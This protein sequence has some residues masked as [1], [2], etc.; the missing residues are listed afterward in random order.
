MA[1][2]SRKLAEFARS[3]NLPFLAVH[4][5]NERRMLAEGSVSRFQLRR[6]FLTIAVEKDFGFDLALWRELSPV[7]RA[8]RAFQPDVVHLT[9]PG[10]TGLLGLYLAHS[11]KI[12]VVAS[13]HTNLHEFAARRL[14]KIAKWA[15]AEAAERFCLKIL[16][17]FY[18][19]ARVTLAPNPE[20]VQ[21]LNTRTGKPS[22]LMSRG[23]D[24][25]LFHPARRTV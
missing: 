25:D 2:T 22:F 6:G 18:S 14:Q 9:S 13:W 24:A 1:T 8:L 21:W 17:L 5:G 23:V 20:W 10:D 15:P 7:T 3:R 19:G 4:G 11:L 16:G 12:P